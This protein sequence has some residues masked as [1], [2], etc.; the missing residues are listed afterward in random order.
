MSLARLLNETIGIELAKTSQKSNWFKRPLSEQQI[1]YAIDDVLYLQS[2]YN[3]LCQ[4]D[5]YNAIS[6]LLDA[7]IKLLSDQDYSTID[8]DKPYKEKEKK[9]FSAFQWFLYEKILLWRNDKAAARNMPSFKILDK[10]EVES[11]CRTIIGD[12]SDQV[13]EFRSI[14]AS[15][16]NELRQKI[17][18]WFSQAV[19]HDLSRDRT[20]F[21][22]PFSRQEQRKRKNEFYDL[23]KKYEPVKKQ[24]ADQIGN[25]T[26]DYFLNNRFLEQLAMLEPM[27]IAPYK[28]ELVAHFYT[29][30]Y[31]KDSKES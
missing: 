6:E 17:A 11:Y 29:L 12:G 30:T 5:R 26:A 21:E 20:P 24:M 7:E 9:K 19:E 10:K 3:H 22:Y 1:S 4:H 25:H 16:R 27:D 2:L 8:F 31:D 28:K 14:K 23:K 13:P 18:D 15:L